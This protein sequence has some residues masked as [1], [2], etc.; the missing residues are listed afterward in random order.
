MASPLYV[1]SIHTRMYVHTSRTRN[2]FHV[3]SF[4]HIGILDYKESY[5][6]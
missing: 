1:H 6:P 3:I 4:E 2:V 5:G